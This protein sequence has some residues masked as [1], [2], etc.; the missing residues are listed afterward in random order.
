MIRRDHDDDYD[1]SRDRKREKE[2][3]R[4]RSR[5]SDDRGYDDSEVEEGEVLSQEDSRDSMKKNHK[6]KKHRYWSF[7]FKRL[8][9]LSQLK[10][11]FKSK[12]IDIHWKRGCLVL[13]MT[14]TH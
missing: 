3:G 14:L 4:K 1:R 2:R 8:T 11:E 9:R 10:G 7:V 5:H 6:D 12:N 13:S